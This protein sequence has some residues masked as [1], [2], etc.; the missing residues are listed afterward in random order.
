M[1][2]QISNI[3]PEFATH[4]SPFFLPPKGWDELA[5]WEAANFP[6]LFDPRPTFTLDND[7][8]SDNE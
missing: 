6:N 5:K 4:S 7:F 1:S 3:P 8:D 2:V